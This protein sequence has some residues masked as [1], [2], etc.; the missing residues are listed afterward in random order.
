ML[1]HTRSTALAIALFPALASADPRVATTEPAP[2]PEPA[3]PETAAPVPRLRMSVDIDPMDYVAYSGWGVYVG[4]R[5]AATGR[6]RFRI[7]AHGATL[8]SIAVET[9]DNN[10]G[11]DEHINI[12]MTAAASRNFGSGRGG[13]FA[14]GL[15]GA[16]SL[17][18]TAPSGGDI[19]VGAFVVGADAGY[20]W[21]PS[22]RLGL[23][24][25]PHIAAM[26]PLY[27]SNDAK[28]GTE[29]YDLFPVI[30]VAQVYLG[31]ELDVL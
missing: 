10:K 1:T 15:V 12:A 31:Y 20:R 5:P 7:G 22:K 21:F 26:V 16:S 9:N 24:I 13:F 28:V 8:P 11:W 23:T 29:K 14:G 25:T 3:A 4:I 27:L 19:N 6:W 2:A 17:T 18:F 30:P